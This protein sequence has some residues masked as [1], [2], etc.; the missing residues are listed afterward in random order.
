MFEQGSQVKLWKSPGSGS[1]YSLK[2]FLTLWD[3]KEFSTMCA[4]SHSLC[5]ICLSL[6]LRST[7]R[8]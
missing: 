5:R 2:E 1:R 8:L 6:V 4:T 7:L 3:M